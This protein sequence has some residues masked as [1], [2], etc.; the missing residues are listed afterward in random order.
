MKSRKNNFLFDTRVSKVFRCQGIFGTQRKNFL[1][2]LDIITGTA[3]QPGCVSDESGKI[4][5]GK[6]MTLLIS[7]DEP[8]PLLE[9]RFYNEE[10]LLNIEAEI[11]SIIKSGSFS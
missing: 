7:G 10:E 8:V 5:E 11:S 6:F 3:R 9:T 1:C 2:S 4:V